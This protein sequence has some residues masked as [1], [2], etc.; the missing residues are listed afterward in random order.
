M[1]GEDQRCH[2]GDVRREHDSQNDE[3]QGCGGDMEHKVRDVIPDRI[4]A[5]QLVIQPK[6]EVGEGTCLD[7]PPDLPCAGRRG[8]GGV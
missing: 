4:R 1:D 6:G 2:E 7:W 3:Q 8:D 5:A